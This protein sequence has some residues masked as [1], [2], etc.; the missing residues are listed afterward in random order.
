MV[1]SMDLLTDIP[2]TAGMTHTTL[3]TIHHKILHQISE[4]AADTKAV[5]TTKADQVLTETTMEIEDTSKTTGM[6]RGTAFKSGMITTDSTTEDDQTNQHYKNQPEAQVTFKYANQSPMQL[7]Q[8]VRNFITFMKAN[9]VSREQFKINKLLNRNF[10]NEVNESE[11]YSS[12]LDHVQQVVNEDTDLV[13]DALVAAD[14]IDEVECME[15]NTHRKVQ[16]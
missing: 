8:T 2:A 7:M 6:T 11:I 12:N 13:F 3:H 5:Q 1:P 15:Y 16:P 14:Y 4:I 10:N 9:P